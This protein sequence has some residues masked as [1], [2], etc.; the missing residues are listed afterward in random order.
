MEVYAAIDNPRMPLREVPA[1]AQRVE[2]L[3]FS[4]LLVPEA[5]HDPFLMAALALEHTRTLTVATSVVL[6]FPRSPMIVAYAAWDLQ[7]L[8]AGRFALGLGSQVKANV[9][10]RFSV[11]W[12]PPVARML[13]YIGALR[14]IW[15]SWQCGGKL[16]FVAEHYR[17]TRMQPF[18]NPGPIEHP[19]IPIFVGGVN[20]RMMQLAGAAADGLMTHPTNTNPRYLRE[21]VLPQIR[22]GAAR[23]ARPRADVAVIAST[24][25]ATGA[26]PEMVQNERARL[27]QYLSFLYS[28]P[29]YWP[30]LDL[31]GWRDRG[32]RLHQ[33]SREGQWDAMLSVITDEMLDE[34]VPAGTYSEIGPVLRAWYGNLVTG[35]TLRLPDD[36]A[37][38]PELARL[39]HSLRDSPPGHS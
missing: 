2:R 10:D 5:I 21:A 24:F 35:I 36:S 17:F 23:R 37:C 22:A 16:E 34:L 9:V 15:T 31:F 1:Y 32:K 38:D 39:I 8:S 12:K 30:T 20:R 18:F 27:R 28:T 3:G 26:T 19:D 13:D 29:H 11:D 4:G 14:A 6:A 7:S 33:L 25:V